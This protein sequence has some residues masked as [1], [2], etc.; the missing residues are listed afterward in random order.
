M[1]PN[2][3]AYGTLMCQDIMAEVAGCQLLG[4][5]ATLTDYRR[6]SVIG[7]EYPGL[8]VAE[9]Y[10]V[11]GVVYRDVPAPAWDRLDRF[12]GAMYARIAVTVRLADG[13]LMPAET[14]LVR[15]AFRKKLESVDWSF[16]QFLRQGKSRFTTG[17]LGYEQL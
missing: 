7:Q 5:P 13:E 4:Q 1:T 17:Y 12:E 8:V 2:C 15:P 14:Y 16:D 10:A 11:E 6:L 9:G 3:F